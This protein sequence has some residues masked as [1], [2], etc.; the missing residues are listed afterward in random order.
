MSSCP[1]LGDSVCDALICMIVICHVD[2]GNNCPG[3]LS[4]SH[5]ATAAIYVVGTTA[6]YAN[7]RVTTVLASLSLIEEGAM[8][9]PN[10]YSHTERRRTRN[11]RSKIMP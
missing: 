8:A 1:K 10:K 4:R 3:L 9:H 6:K 11:A 2:G 7:S 5:L